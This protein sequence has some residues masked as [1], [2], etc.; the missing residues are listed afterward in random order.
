M[1]FFKRNQSG[2]TWCAKGSFRIDPRK[3][4]V[5]LEAFAFVPWSE[6]GVFSISSLCLSGCSKMSHFWRS[7]CLSIL[8]FMSIRWC[9]TSWTSKVYF[10]LY[11]KKFKYVT[12]PAQ[13]FFIV[14]WDIL[15]QW[16]S[17]VT[18]FR[19]WKNV[20]RE[21]A[22]IWISSSIKWNRL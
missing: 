19:S 1:S 18:A 21:V 8:C 6:A 5:I 16:Q 20:G 10:I 15:R 9:Y 13:H 22:R 12:L 14:N 4:K 17:F 11:L 3:I 7:R 2:N